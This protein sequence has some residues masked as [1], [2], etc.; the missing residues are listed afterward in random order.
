MKNGLKMK[1]NYKENEPTSFYP[2]EELMGRGW[3]SHCDDCDRSP[4]YDESHKEE[5]CKC[6]CHGNAEWHYNNT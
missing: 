2:G 3:Y 5:H 1:V 6:H 4:T